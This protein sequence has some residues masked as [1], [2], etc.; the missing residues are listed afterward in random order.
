MALLIGVL[1]GR[2]GSGNPSRVRVQSR[3]EP[4][5]Q[6]PNLLGTGRIG[7]GRHTIYLFTSI[8]FPS[9]SLGKITLAC[10]ELDSTNI[11][12]SG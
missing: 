11:Y 9:I 10:D 8:H 3:F 6:H 1:A 5:G 2:V 4:V 7:S 12:N